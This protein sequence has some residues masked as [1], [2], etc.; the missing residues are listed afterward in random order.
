MAKTFR[1]TFWYSSA[2]SLAVDGDRGGT[3]HIVEH[4]AEDAADFRAMVTDACTHDV[5]DEI[6]FGPV[7][8]KR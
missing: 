8:E 7:S 1:A 3:R 4:E 2:A 5:D 6:T